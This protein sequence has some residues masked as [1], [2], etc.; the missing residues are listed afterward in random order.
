MGF[1]H[2]RFGEENRTKKVVRLFNETLL[3]ASSLVLMVRGAACLG[4]DVFEGLGEAGLLEEV[5]QTAGEDGLQAVVLGGDELG[6]LLEGGEMTRCVR[7]TEIMVA[8][9][10]DSAFEQSVQ[11]AEV[12]VHFREI[13]PPAR[14]DKK[15]LQAGIPAD[16]S[17]AA[18]ER[19]VN[20][21]HAA[22]LNA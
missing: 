5:V 13:R 7:I 2:T 6:N 19:S 11:G 22:A 12:G 16:N 15:C 20:H 3:S 9:E 14:E 21:A 17:F 10:L 18:C 4:F 8:D 1:H